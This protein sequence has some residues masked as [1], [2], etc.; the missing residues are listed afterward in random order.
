MDLVIEEQ[1]LQLLL[2]LDLR[3]LDIDDVPPTLIGNRLDGG[4][5]PRA[6][7]TV[8]QEP[9]RIRNALAIVPLAVLQEA[10]SLTVNPNLN[11]VSGI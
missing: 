6:R 5:L 8:V 2:G 11:G 3:E 7:W 1:V 9:Q 10:F 4:R